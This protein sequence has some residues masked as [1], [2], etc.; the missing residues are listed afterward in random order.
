[1]ASALA[2]GKDWVSPTAQAI[3]GA[4]ALAGVTGTVQTLQAVVES[5]GLVVRVS[6]AELEQARMHARRVRGRVGRSGLPPP[7]SP[8][9]SS[10][11]SAATCLPAP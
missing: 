2:G 1:M 10:S 4:K 7:R 9:R 11:P 8:P 3:A 6:E 5:E